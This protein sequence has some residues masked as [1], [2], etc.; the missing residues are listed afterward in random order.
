MARRLSGATGKARLDDAERARVRD[1]VHGV[2]RHRGLI[3]H[4]LGNVSKKPLRS[5]ERSVTWGLRLGVFRL[6]RPGRAPRPAAIVVKE[7]VDLLPRRREVRGFVNAVLRTLA[8]GIDAPPVVEAS[9]PE[10]RRTIPWAD[11]GGLRLLEDWLP[12]PADDTAA[13]L[14]A[15]YSHP[16]W[17]V[18]RWRAELGAETAAE[19]ARA[20]TSMPPFTIRANR[21]RARRDELAERLRARGVE[22]TP[23][24]H[25]DALHVVGGRSLLSVPE[26]EEGLFYVQDETSMDVVR[27]LDVRPGHRVLDLCAAPG[28][29][30]THIAERLEGEGTVCACDVTPAK[31]ARIEENAR[32]LGRSPLCRRNSPA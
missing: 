21:R 26:F 29:K 4:L 3:D 7:A 32:R 6:I 28:G 11:G 2:L 1:L 30:A 16:K 12:D 23:G 27:R 14:A 24:A 22:T 18:E 20:G 17:I 31:L 8:R 15:A 13:Y 25:S 19:A 9:V 5:L 10:G